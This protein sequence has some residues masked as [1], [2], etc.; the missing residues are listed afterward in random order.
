MSVQRDILHHLQCDYTESI[1]DPLWKHIY[2]SKGMKD[3]LQTPELQQLQRVKQLGPTHLVYPGAVHTRF[4]HSL[5]VYHVAKQIIT[6][7]V[8]HNTSEV[9]TLQGVTNFLLAAL[10]HDLGHFPYAH[11]LKE[12]VPLSH[13][14]LGR[15]IILNTSLA[16]KISLIPEGDPE[17]VGLII[18]NSIA[19]QNPEIEIYRKVLS[20]PMDPDKLDYLNRDAF[21][22]GV[23]YGIQDTDIII[24][25]LI[26]RRNDPT[27]LSP[28]GREL[29]DG[30]LLSKYLM[31]K[32]VYWHPTVRGAT[33][34][35]KEGVLQ[36]FS[37][38]TLQAKD[39]Y[40]LDDY[41]FELLT[42]S[43]LLK[44]MLHYLQSGKVYQ[45]VFH[46]SY[47]DAPFLT[48]PQGQNDL[49]NSLKEASTLKLS[50]TDILI[51]V[52][53]S[54]SFEVPEVSQGTLHITP[55][56]NSLGE[57]LTG[58]LR[59]IRIFINPNKGESLPQRHVQKVVQE[60]LSR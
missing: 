33:A 4:N 24:E 5:G 48:T 26:S 2:I 29:L 18:D 23:P 41:S 60:L 50:D 1:R 39:M 3:L 12:V 49:K 36:G 51:D 7:M 32:H 52:P 21:F 22:C 42:T 16:H 38:G 53:E 17:M 40:G 35:I 43:P 8:K 15:E 25:S 47:T 55:F 13:E 57:D 54:I 20:G 11:S 44:E 19:I 27:E 46:T 37:H 58:A 45:E 14:S 31:Y 28:Q 9:F 6:A 34:M 59:R 56:S 30:I 10:L